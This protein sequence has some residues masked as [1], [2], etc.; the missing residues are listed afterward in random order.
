MA[1]DLEA[2]DHDGVF[3]MAGWRTLAGLG[4]PGML[5][6]TAYGGSGGDPITVLAALEALGSVCADHGLIFSLGAHLWGCTHPIARFGDESQKSRLLPR[7][8]SGEAMGALAAS[9]PESGSDIFSLKTT[10]R[11]SDQGYVLRGKKVFITNGPV[12][13]VFLVLATLDPAKG[14]LAIT[15][16]LVEKG[17]PGLCIGGNVEKMGLRTTPMSEVCLEDCELPVE[18][19]L[20]QEGNGMAIFNFAMQWERAFI[21]GHV[22]GA[23]QRVLDRC[24]RYARERRQFGQA[25]GSFQAVSHTL[26]E[27]QQR[28]EISR[29]LLFH[30]ASMKQKGEPALKETARTKLYLSEAWV[31]NCH[32]ALRLHGARGYLTEQGLE[33][34]LRDAIGSQIYSGTSE[35]QREVLARLLKL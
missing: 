27:M 23:M 32:D 9:E 4:L 17:T 11:R 18:N 13:D 14:P 15:A 2:R 30:L 21:L 35:I 20:G 19:R 29:L 16:F 25:I 7:L 10:A 1:R 33:R 24:V 6:P 26:V 8:C 3:D 5:V 28:L 31:S 22:G 34:E 12:A